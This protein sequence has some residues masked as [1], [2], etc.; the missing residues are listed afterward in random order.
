MRHEEFFLNL[1]INNIKCLY[2]PE[3][4]FKEY[5]KS[6]RYYDKNGNKLRNRAEDIINIKII[7]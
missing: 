4:I 7:R 2:C 1:W 6:I 5:D 3:F